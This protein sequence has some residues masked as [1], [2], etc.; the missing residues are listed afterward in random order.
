[1]YEQKDDEC[2]DSTRKLSDEIE[3]AERMRMER[4]SLRE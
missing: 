4:D 1:M 3:K 2:A